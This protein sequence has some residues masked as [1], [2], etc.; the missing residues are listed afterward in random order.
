MTPKQQALRDLDLARSH[1][2]RQLHQAG[3]Q[4]NPRAI[5][6]RSVRQYPWAWLGV[7]AAGGLLAVRMLLPARTSGPGKIER[8]NSGASATKGGLIALIVSSA[9]AMARQTA[10]KYGSRYLQDYLAQ[11]FSRHEGERPRA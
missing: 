9:F 10:W 3:E 7:A 4:Y 2:G 5:V 11:N 1:L 8:D 6:T